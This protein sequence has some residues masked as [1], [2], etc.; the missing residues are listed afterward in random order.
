ML[1]RNIGHCHPGHLAFRR[2]PCALSSRAPQPP[3]G[4]LDHFQPRNPKT[5]WAVQMDAHFAVSIKIQHLRAKHARR[6]H[7]SRQKWQEGVGVA[8]T[9][10]RAS[11]ALDLGDLLGLS[12]L[13][14]LDGNL[15]FP[16][17][18]HHLATDVFGAVVDPYR[19]WLAAPFDDLIKYG[20]CQKTIW[21]I[22][23]PT[24]GNTNSARS[25]KSSSIP[26]LSRLQLPSTVGSRS[27]RPSSCR[28]SV[29][30]RSTKRNP[31]PRP[32]W[33]R[34]GRPAHSV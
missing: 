12:G 32:C 30:R 34:P 27:A 14:M 26:S 15:M 5:S 25:E 24:I 8:L 3:T 16:G 28:S 2:N 20:K 33:A 22:V 7:R 23:S 13:D 31:S 17:P 4:S 9:L 21:K 18:F 1:A 11:V 6:M 29:D 10:D 19:A